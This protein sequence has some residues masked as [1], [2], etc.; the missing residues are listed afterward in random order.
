MNSGVNFISD[1]T[2][3]LLLNAKNMTAGLGLGLRLGLAWQITNYIRQIHEAGT[4]WFR[5]VVHE[6]I[7]NLLESNHT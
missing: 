3:A 2:V 1:K 7:L 4:Q 6:D 5:S